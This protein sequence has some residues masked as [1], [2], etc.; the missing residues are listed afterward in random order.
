MDDLQVKQR[1]IIADIDYII[2]NKVTLLR[3]GAMDADT[4]REEQ[5]RLE[6][7][8]GVVGEEIKIYAESV[9]E[10]LRYVMT[11]SEVVKDAGLYF[12]YALDSEKREITSLVFTEL[13]FKDRQL[14]SYEARDG[15]KAL[16]QRRTAVLL[17]KAQTPSREISLNGVSGSPGRIR[18]YDQLVTLC[19]MISQRGGLYHHPSLATVGCEVLRADFSGLLP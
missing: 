16:L 18:T 1:T 7:K 13:V 17:K 11:F 2:Q 6:T 14:V 5:R 9:P 4:V 19:P 3:T 8:L 15:F 10:M 12:K